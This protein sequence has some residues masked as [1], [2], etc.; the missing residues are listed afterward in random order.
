MEPLS[1][2]VPQRQAPVMPA[3]EGNATMEFYDPK[4]FGLQRAVPPVPPRRDSLI[5]TAKKFASR[6]P[7]L[8]MGKLGGHGARADKC[9]SWAPGQY[10]GMQ[11][12][13][14]GLESRRHL[15]PRSSSLSKSTRPIVRE[16][17]SVGEEDEEEKNASNAL[18]VVCDSPA[19]SPRSGPLGRRLQSR[20]RSS[21]GPRSDHGGSRRRRKRTTLH[22]IRRT[23][24]ADDIGLMKRRLNSTNSLPEETASDVD[25]ICDNLYSNNSSC[26]GSDLE[27]RYF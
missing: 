1:A 23:T 5:L 15:R 2:P 16:D 6:S 11:D 8:R 3:P 7:P 4:K 21:R 19:S 12:S 22:N 20:S 17:K 26:S 27:V 18:G 25:A 24:S 9:T 10:D 13:L 14:P